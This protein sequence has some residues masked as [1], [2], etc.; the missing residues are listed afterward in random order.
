[1]WTP[2]RWT[3]LLW[4]LYIPLANTPSPAVTSLLYFQLSR[5]WRNWPAKSKRLRSSFHFSFISAHGW[6]R[7]QGATW[8]C[9]IEMHFYVNRMM[10][11]WKLGNKTKWPHG[12][13]LHA[14]VMRLLYYWGSLPALVRPCI[15]QAELKQPSVFYSPVGE[16][17]KIDQILLECRIDSLTPFCLQ[18]E[19]PLSWT[20][21]NVIFDPFW[22]LLVITVVFLVLTCPYFSG[23]WPLRFWVTF[24]SASIWFQ[25]VMLPGSC[26]F[27]FFKGITSPIGCFSSSL[28]L[29]A[30]CSQLVV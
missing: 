25:T 12:L 6:C 24:L 5:T 10:F 27:V 11:R 18:L 1:M 23:R 19:A 7:I 2:R 16:C 3:S 14:R 13:I 22:A 20:G 30:T 15:V 9:V 17:I 4:C 29:A 21:S 8:L 26:C 28:C